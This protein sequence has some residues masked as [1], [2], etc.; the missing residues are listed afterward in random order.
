MDADTYVLAFS[1][2]SNDGI[3]KPFTISASGAITTGVQLEHDITYNWYNSLI[4]L[5]ADTYVLAYTGNGN[6]GYIKTF[7]IP[8]NG[9]SITQVAS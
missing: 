1:D 3:I 4:Q 7:T 6:D 9:C 2:N 5:D 8:A